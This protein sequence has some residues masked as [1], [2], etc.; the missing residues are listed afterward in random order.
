MLI[1]INKYD[2]IPAN[3]RVNTTKKFQSQT[4]RKFVYAKMT[5]LTADSYQINI[6][7]E[8]KIIHVKC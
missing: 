2:F 1:K 7:Q 5:D 8:T 3:I 6:G 4:K